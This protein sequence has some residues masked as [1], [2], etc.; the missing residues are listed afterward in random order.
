MMLTDRAQALMVLDRQV[1]RLYQS[2]ARTARIAAAAVVAMDG[3][4]FGDLAPRCDRSSRRVGDARQQAQAWATTALSVDAS[5]MGGGRCRSVGVT[6]TG[7]FTKLLQT[8]PSC[9][10][11]PNQN[12]HTHVRA[13][14]V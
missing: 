14:S 6:S 1:G 5:C 11:R 13:R 2:S 7:P 8:T 3:E 10:S 12:I 9:H 4:C